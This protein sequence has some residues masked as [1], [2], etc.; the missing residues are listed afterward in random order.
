MI[1]TSPFAV[2][3]LPHPPGR[4]RENLYTLTES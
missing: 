2:T 3:L 1:D 4:N